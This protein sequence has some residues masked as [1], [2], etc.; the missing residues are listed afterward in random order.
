MDA[1]EKY[2]LPL[3]SAIGNQRFLIALRDSFIGIMPVVM[4]GSI[5]VL[6]NAFFVDIP[7]QFGLE[8]IT[9]NFQWLVDINGLIFKGSLAIVSIL[10]VFTLGINVAK[11]YKT[12]T[13]SAGLVSLSAFII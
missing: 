8:G 2:L 12:D 6:L 13:L 11:I 7:A 3:A 5:A 4:T 9:R 1:I 10:F